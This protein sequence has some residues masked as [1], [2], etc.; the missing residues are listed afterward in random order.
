MRAMP[1]RIEATLANLPPPPLTPA[2]AAAAAAAATAAVA[3]ADAT[4][5][6]APGTGHGTSCTSLTP[7]ARRTN[8]L[9]SHVASEAVSHVASEAAS[10][11]ASE[12]ASHV[13]SEA[14]R[15]TEAA[16]RAAISEGLARTFVTLD[17]EIR[18]HPQLAGAAKA[19]GSTAQ[20][21][22]A[23]AMAHHGAPTARTVLVHTVHVHTVHARTVH[24]RTVPLAQYTHAHSTRPSPHTRS[25]SMPSLV[26]FA[27]HSVALLSPLSRP[28]LW[29]QSLITVL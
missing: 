18:S 10:H 2:A 19:S 24:A 5:E 11:V 23:A 6:A 26:H 13:A 28:A 1:A 15:S 8:A 25:V 27:R 9:A 20:A 12:A 22:R 29:G 17:L 16:Y 3:T 4:A 7:A 21:R 14:A